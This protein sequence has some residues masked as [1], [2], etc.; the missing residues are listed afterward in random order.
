MLRGTPS[1]TKS[2]TKNQKIF[3]RLLKIWKEK[4]L[5]WPL[6]ILAFIRRILWIKK[7][8][9][10]QVGRLKLSRKHWKRI[11]MNV[12]SQSRST[13][14]LRFTLRNLSIWLIISRGIVWLQ[15]LLDI[16]LLIRE[17]NMSNRLTISISKRIRWNQLM[18]V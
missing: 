12:L 15:M 17:R 14:M 18:R 9:I 13:T 11:K 1:D 5:K 7:L 16:I 2:L 8:I 3:K 10:M 4:F 6:I